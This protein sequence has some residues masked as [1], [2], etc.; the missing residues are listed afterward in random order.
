MIKGMF[1]RLIPRNRKKKGDPT[2]GISEALSEFYSKNECVIDPDALENMPGPEVD[3]NIESKHTILLMDDQ[4]VVFYLFEFDFKEIKR[5]FDYDVLENYKIVKC[6]GP[7][8]GFI[9]AKYIKESTDEVVIAILDLTLGKIIKLKDGTSIVHDGVDIALEVISKQP[10]CKIGLCTAHML[11]E[12]N[13]IVHSLMKKFNAAT[14]HNMLDYAFN[15]NADRAGYLHNMIM[16][17]NHAEK[18]GNHEASWELH[19]ISS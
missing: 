16:E 7:D 6:G 9:A 2:D 4:E 12:S 1:E 13:P 19:K 8:A 14:G 10:K 15:K 5:R 3:G 17:V 18:S 11:S